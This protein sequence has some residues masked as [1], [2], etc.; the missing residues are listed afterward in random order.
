M[1]TQNLI[2][3]SKVAIT[4]TALCLFANNVSADDSTTGWHYP[5]VQSSNAYGNSQT[6]SFNT[7]I[8]GS[9]KLTTEQ[10]NERADLIPP[11]LNNRFYVRLGGNASAEG[12]VGIKNIATYNN[13]NTLTTGT[14]ANSNVKNA[15]N[16]FEMAFGYT[17]TDFA[18]DLEWL[19]LKSVVVN[20]VMTGINPGFGFTSTIKGDALLLNVY[21]ILKDMYNVKLYGLINGSYSHN[22]STNYISTGP[23]SVQNRYYLGFGGG[24]G[25]RFNIIS[26]LYA[27][28][29][30]RYLFLGKVRMEATNLPYYINFNAQRTWIGMSFR[31]LWLL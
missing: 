6:D 24:L 16:N 29:A 13:Y 14:I 23:V 2:K 5:S 3:L 31:L 27:D 10:L 25:A 30:G 22:R 4:F 7:A 1:N 28:V 12:V 9:N 11:K 19:A 26:K 15:S 8:N 18:M 21:W 20:G 17:W